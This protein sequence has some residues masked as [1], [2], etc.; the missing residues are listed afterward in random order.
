MLL[1]FKILFLENNHKTVLEIL[2]NSFLFLKMEN[3]L[4]H[5]IKQTFTILNFYEYTSKFIFL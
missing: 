1:C 5:M 2:K 3:Y 4:N